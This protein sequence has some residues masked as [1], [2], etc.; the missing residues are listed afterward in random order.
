MKSQ[1][2]NYWVVAIIKLDLSY[3]QLIAFLVICTKSPGISQDLSD[4]M[5]IGKTT[6]PVFSWNHSL[7]DYSE[8]EAYHFHFIVNCFLVI[9]H[10]DFG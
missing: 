4:P 2:T 7:W 9:I 8:S 10:Y 1:W 3:A 6:L 5:E